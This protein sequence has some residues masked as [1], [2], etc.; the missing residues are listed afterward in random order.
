MR[1][2]GSSIM[3][4]QIIEQIKL[5]TKFKIMDGTKYFLQLPLCDIKNSTKTSIIKILKKKQ[6]Q[7]THVGPK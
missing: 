3:R 1:L 5:E 2:I 4:W 7:E 6:V